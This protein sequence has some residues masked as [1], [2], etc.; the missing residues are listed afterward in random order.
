[1]I[2][3]R[4]NLSVQ[5]RTSLF[6]TKWGKKILAEDEIKGVRDIFW[7]V[8]LVVMR[9]LGFF[10]IIVVFSC[11]VLF[12]S[13]QPHGLNH[14]SFRIL[15]YLPEFAQTQVHWV[16]YTI[17]PFYPLLPSSP[18]TLS[19]SQHQDLFQ[20]VAFHFRWSKYW[21]FS[22]SPSNDYSG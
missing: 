1:M 8:F 6:K 12:N 4:K 15:H 5:C 22:L 14:A 3:S 9:C 18:P 11:L 16:S 7:E 13:L 10:L 17:Q 19:L 21:N 20:G 2:R